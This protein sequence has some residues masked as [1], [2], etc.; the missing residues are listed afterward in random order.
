[1]LDKEVLP[2]FAKNDTPNDY[3]GKLRS[4]VFDSQRKAAGEF[5]VHHST[6]SRYEKNDYTGAGRE[7]IVPLGYFASLMALFVEQQEQVLTVEGRAEWQQFLVEQMNKVLGR[8]RASY[9]YHKLLRDWDELLTIGSEYRTKFADR[10]DKFPNE[11][12]LTPGEVKAELTPDVSVPGDES[13]S[14]S[15]VGDYNAQADRG[16]VASVNITKIRRH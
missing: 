15:I 5:G 11:V 16:G 12:T 6:I 4:R 3:A 8:Y 13:R 10:P 14:Q 2:E 1:M 9:N 7:T